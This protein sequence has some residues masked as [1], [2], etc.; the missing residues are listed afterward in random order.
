MLSWGREVGLDEAQVLAVWFHDAIYDAK[1]QRNEED[2]AELAQRL[3]AAD[4]HPQSQIDTV[5]RIVLDTKRH[6]PTIPASAKVLDLDLGSLALPWPEFIANTAAIRSEYA[7]VADA[8]F[9]V[10]RRTFLAK[11][12]ERPQLFYTP[13]G[14][15]REATARANIARLVAELSD[16]RD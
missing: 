4:G 2:S 11:L 1:S 7:H 9:R 13:W 3:L 5:V 15:A 12:L 10:G 8:D 6:A 16:T 14:M